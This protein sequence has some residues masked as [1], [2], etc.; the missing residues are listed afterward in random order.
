MAVNEKALKDNSGNYNFVKGADGKPLR[1]EHGK[2]IIEHDL[3][4]IAEAFIKFAK[5]QNLDF[6]R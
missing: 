6:W 4:E 5:E 3:D 2:P 1:D